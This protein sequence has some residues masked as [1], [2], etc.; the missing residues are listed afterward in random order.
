MHFPNALCVA[1]ALLGAVIVSTVFAQSYP[2][3]PIT[4]VVPF[5]PGT[6]T[7]L[8]ARPVADRLS[9]SLGQ[10][11]IIDYR[12]G[13]AGG[14]VGARGVSKA[15]PDGYTLLLCP[16]GPLVVAPALYKDI[17]YDPV[18]NFTPIATLFSVPQ[19][20][21][22]HPSV[23][24]NSIQELVA[25]AKANPGK[26]NFASPGYGTQPHLL[27]EML[28]HATGINLIHVPY[29]GPAQAMTDLIGGQVQMYFETAALFI[30]QAKGGKAKI[31]AVA[32]EERS[33]LLADIPTTTE[34]GFP[35]LR[36]TFWAGVVAPAGTPAAIIQKL[37]IAI[38]E[39][40]GSAEMKPVLE[41]L[42]AKAKLGTPQEFAAFMATETQ[43][44][45]AIVKAANIKID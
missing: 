43:R 23:P 22:V 40:V 3:R 41:K 5:P 28:K 32:D 44:W 42:S 12:P 36:G 34:G 20:L 6:N 10:P 4:L 25:Y 45:T 31:L 17:G 37:N 33:S 11:A 16:P 24:V 39:I 7:D 19:V 27:G 9:V 30:P 13:G 2:T 18:K 8:V 26:I 21:G 14:T 15:E 35:G 29:K 38:N 1:A